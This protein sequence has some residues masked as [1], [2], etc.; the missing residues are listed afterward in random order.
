MEAQKEYEEFV[1]A[2]GGLRITHNKLDEARSRVMQA[3]VGLE[4][5]EIVEDALKI[6]RTYRGELNECMGIAQQIYNATSGQ[7]KQDLLKI[8]KTVFTNMRSRTVTVLPQ[9]ESMYSRGELTI[10]KSGF[11]VRA[12]IQS[13]AIHT[14]D[15]VANII[16]RK[17][18]VVQQLAELSG[19]K[20]WISK[21]N[22]F[23]D[24]L[25]DVDSIN[26]E[27]AID[28]KES[29][30]IPNKRLSDEVY[31]KF[32]RPARA[33][34]CSISNDSISLL[35]EDDERRSSDCFKL[36]LD[37]DTWREEDLQW[38]SAVCIV[39]L[40]SSMRAI[41]KNYKE[42]AQPILDK[43]DSSNKKL[44]D[45]FGKELLFAGL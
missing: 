45:A 8:F 21:L 29:I 10:G 13:S 7:Y 31:H 5:S 39:Q 32:D 17:E 41:I 42:N 34:Q 16:K 24:A 25:P 11:G 36:Y 33:T 27:I 18:E 44:K 19:T 23:A 9:Y 22:A 26:G 20:E 15:H 30:S 43:L 37:K 40:E 2:Q 4:N 14:F 6:L 1:M 38:E 35:Y 28:L 3:N 12:N